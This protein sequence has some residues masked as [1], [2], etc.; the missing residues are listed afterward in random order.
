MVIPIG[1]HQQFVCVAVTVSRQHVGQFIPDGSLV[2]CI[3]N[4]ITGHYLQAEPCR[5]NRL[6]ASVYFHQTEHGGICLHIILIHRDDRQGTGELHIV[7]ILTV[8]NTI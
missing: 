1:F 4:D 2:D 8:H 3:K 5:N 7:C 6:C